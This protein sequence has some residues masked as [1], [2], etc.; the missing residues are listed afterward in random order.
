MAKPF[1]KTELLL[2]VNNVLRIEKAENSLK[3]VM[4][5]LAE[6]NKILNKLS[7]TDELTN[8]YNRRQL[9]KSLKEKIYDAERYSMPLS[10]ILF[11]IDYFKKINDNYGHLSGDEVLRKVSSVFMKGLRKT[12]IAGRYGGEEFLLVFPNT[13]LER[14]LKIAKTLSEQVE[15]LT[16][17][18]VPDRK[19]TVSGG[20]CEYNNEIKYEDFLSRAD[21]LLYIAKNNGKG[22]I[23]V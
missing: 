13:P 2:R 4:G 19:I 15:K 20:V 16:F 11:D 10:I 5:Q 3:K 21:D 22:R 9:I 12:D 1:N 14:C 7:I 18:S 8:L 6:K 23:E 17:K